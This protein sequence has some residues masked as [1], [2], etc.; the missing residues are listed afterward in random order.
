MQVHLVNGTLE[1][2]VRKKDLVLFISTS[3]IS[4]ISMSRSVLYNWTESATFAFLEIVV[5]ERLLVGENADNGLKKASW[6]KIASLTT[7]ALDYRFTKQQLHNKLS[8]LKK[9]YCTMKVMCH[10][11]WL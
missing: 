2:L 3:E 9:D 8:S 1:E 6:T 11:D 4:F 7:E 5:E 10:F